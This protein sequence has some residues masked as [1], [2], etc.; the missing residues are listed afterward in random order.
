MG[1][2]MLCGLQIFPWRSS[3]CQELLSTQL[4]A[5]HHSQTAVDFL[6]KVNTFL[7]AFP[8]S[9]DEIKGKRMSHSL[10][11]QQLL[12]LKIYK[13][14]VKIKMVHFREKTNQKTEIQWHTY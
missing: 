1:P 10:I 3:R 13:F 8:S 2:L 11:F 5:R 4:R 12:N 7:F 14:K 6:E 9:I